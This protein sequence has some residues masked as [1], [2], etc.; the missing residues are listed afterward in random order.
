LANRIEVRMNVSQTHDCLRSICYRGRQRSQSS[1]ARSKTQ[2]TF[3]SQTGFRLTLCFKSFDLRAMLNIPLCLCCDNTG[4][5]YILQGYIRTNCHASGDSSGGI[6]SVRAVFARFDSSPSDASA[7][8]YKRLLAQTRL[9]SFGFSSLCLSRAC[10]GKLFLL[11]MQLISRY[12][13]VGGGNSTTLL[14]L[15]ATLVVRDSDISIS[16]FRPLCKTS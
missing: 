6:V 3:H 14:Q 5:N 7:G 15:P 12:V 1:Q 9:W 2:K 16:V 13:R 11:N 8:A 10:L 4:R